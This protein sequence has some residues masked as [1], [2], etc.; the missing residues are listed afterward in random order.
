MEI[1]ES[2][3]MDNHQLSSSTV[4]VAVAVNGSKN[5]MQALKWALKFTNEGK[6]SFRIL[7]VRPKITMVPTPMGNYLHVSKVRD[8]IVSAYLKEIECKTESMLLPYIKMCSHGKVEAEAAVTESDDVVEAISGEVNK[9]RISRLVIGA[10]SR[11]IF[12]SQFKGTKVSSRLSECIPRF[13]TMYVVSKGKLKS[14]HASTSKI[15]SCRLHGAASG[16]TSCSSSFSQSSREHSVPSQCDREKSETGSQS[17]SSQEYF[18]S[19]TSN[20]SDMRSEPIYQSSQTDTISWN[21]DKVSG[22]DFTKSSIISNNEVNVD[23]ELERLRIELKHLQGMYNVA[24]KESLDAS[25]QLNKLKASQE[26]EA[27]KLNSIR[28]KEEKAIQTAKNE[29]ERREKIEKEF[30]YVRQCVEKE[31]LE[32]MD[33]EEYAAREL[34]EKQRLEDVIACRKE[35][36]Y[37][38]YE[39]EEIKSA[40]SSFSDELKIGA[41]AN[42]TVYKASLHHT[43]AA[44]KVLNSTEGKGT[45]QFNQELEILSRI[46]HPHLLLLLG[47]CPNRSCLVYEYME[48]G[49]LEDRLQCKNNTPPLPWQYRYRIIYEIATALSFLHNCKPSPIIHRDLKPANILLDKN[50]V[51]KIGDVGLSTIMAP[52]DFGESSMYKNTA[53]AGTFFYIDPEYQRSGIVSEKSDIYALGMIILRV[54]TGKPAMGLAHTAE[55]AM[56]E[57]DFVNILDGSAGHWPIEETRKLALLGLNC[58]ELRRKDR[59]NL[60]DHILPV[61]E[62]LAQIACNVQDLATPS[63]FICPILQ[64]VMDDPCVASD[65]YTYERK[66]IEKWYEQNDKSPLT[67]MNLQSKELILNQSLLSAIKKWKITC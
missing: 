48:N 25:Q 30:K 40:T 26:E 57:D 27:L 65:G 28:R 15:D 60:R 23:F 24:Q 19:S 54:I 51:S 6:A 10:S 58:V 53:P 56:E 32:R 45:K 46:R 13:C 18:T 47:A 2:E 36:Y 55:K 64:E 1:E 4:T 3:E 14:I 66:A 43:V 39:W 12:T 20:L 9:F 22:S 33:A 21:S 7:Y 16:I 52:V 49:S 42:G 17:F 61:L 5:S 29:R 63:H 50:Y 67:N 34:N 8:E 44:V 62:K 11:N 59:P 37:K 38:K 35:N 31:A 41:G